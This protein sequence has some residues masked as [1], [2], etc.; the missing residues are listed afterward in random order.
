MPDHPLLIQLDTTLSDRVPQDAVDFAGSW[1]KHSRRTYGSEAQLETR[2]GPFA[3]VVDLRWRGTLTGTA[4][5]SGIAFL[6]TAGT[7]YWAKAPEISPALPVEV[8]L[9]AYAD[10]MRDRAT[11]TSSVGSAYLP[12]IPVPI[13]SDLDAACTVDEGVVT[14]GR[15]SRI[16]QTNDAA[17]FVLLLPRNLLTVGRKRLWRVRDQIVG[18][19]PLDVRQLLTQRRS[20]T[21][22]SVV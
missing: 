17:I 14:S 6:L 8:S 10:Y 21:A 2:A 7:L 9:H 12:G 16:A 13:A 22:P 20:G 3:D 5:M 18:L 19:L 11:L 4:P 1:S 15:V